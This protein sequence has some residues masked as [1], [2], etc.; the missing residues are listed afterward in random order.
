MSSA[1]NPPPLALYDIMHPM[2]PSPA[3][4][5][6]YAAPDAIISEQSRNNN[7]EPS[8]EPLTEAE[9]SSFRDKLI[10]MGLVT[11]ECTEDGRLS[12]LPQNA[13]SRE[14]E[15]VNMVSFYHLS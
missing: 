3:P 6:D 5:E 13:S 11:G 8:P 1:D 2:S 9:R 12:A 4:L 7:K 10:E 14:R 15:L